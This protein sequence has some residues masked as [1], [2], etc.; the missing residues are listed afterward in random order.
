MS[1]ITRFNPTCN[2]GLHLGHI[3]TLL[4]NERFAHARGGRFLV[5]FDDVAV[6]GADPYRTNDIDLIDRI[7]EE[8]RRDIEWLGI[9]VDDWISDRDM[10]PVVESVWR[11]HNFVRPPYLIEHPAQYVHMPA[12]WLAYP[13]QPWYTSMRAVIDGELGTTNL[14]RGEEIAF[15]GGLQSWFMDLFGYPRPRFH[16]L[17][18]LQG[19]GGDISKTAGGHKIAD[20]RAN[21]VTPERV[22]WMLREA[23][24]AIPHFEWDF[25]NLKARPCL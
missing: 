3:S 1:V 7:R 15:D 16:Y 19:P 25:E 21:G 4:V 18:R 8:Q 5:R 17:P 6:P 13:Y 14:I 9:P 23:C 10:M 2:G 20:L 24:L 11:D 12:G 22:H